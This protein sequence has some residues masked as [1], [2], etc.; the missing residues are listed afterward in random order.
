[1]TR[2][3]TERLGSGNEAWVVSERPAPIV[4]SERKITT[5]PLKGAAPSAAVEEPQERSLPAETRTELST[6]PLK[7]LMAKSESAV[8]SA[9]DYQRGGVAR[10][11]PKV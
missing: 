4:T 9:E 5:A 8:V 2:A 6:Y 7:M 3:N 11:L 1:M 10:T